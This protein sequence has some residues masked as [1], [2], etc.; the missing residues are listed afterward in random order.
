MKPESLSLP[1]EVSADLDRLGLEFLAGILAVEIERHPNNVEALAEL[2]HV[3]TRQGL[4]ERGLAIDRSLARL[5]PDSP[6]VHY[7]LAC[8]LALL[9]RAA[10]ALASLERA[11]ELGYSDPDFLRAD[12]DL[13]SLRGEKRFEELLA[14]LDQQST[15]RDP[16]SI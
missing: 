10:E 6:T 9:A 8:S 4:I 2:G 12:D 5:V 13:A 11:I 1:A 3:Y 7:N 14:A 15:R 16:R